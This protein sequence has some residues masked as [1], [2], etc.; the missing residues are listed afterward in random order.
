[1][2]AG[3]AVGAAAGPVGA[4]VGGLVG[5]VAGGM[6]ASVLQDTALDA[7][8]IN[9]TEQRQAN[10]E[11]NP[12]SA[13]AGDVAGSMA[14]FSPVAVGETVG[15]RL[16][17][18]AGGAVLQGGIEAGQELYQDGK[19]DPL[20]IA[21]T[22]A[23][24][25]VL[26][27]VN[28]LGSKVLNVGERLV[29]GRPNRTS[30]PEAAQ[31][32]ADVGDPEHEIAVGDSEL[33]E[34]DPN[35]PAQPTTGNPQ[36]APERSDREY[37]KD[38]AAAPGAD[39]GVTQGDMDP[40][41]QAALQE[42]NP[43]TPPAAPEPAPPVQR[44]LGMPPGNFQPPKPA[45]EAPLDRPAAPQLTPGQRAIA[46]SKRAQKLSLEPKVEAGFPA[47]GEP[48]A[49]GENEATAVASRPMPELQGQTPINDSITPAQKVAG[50][51]P[52]ARAQDFGKPVRVETHEGDVRRSH[53]DAPEAWENVSPYDYGYFGKTVGPDKDPIDFA[54]P[55]EGSPDLGDKHFIIDQKDATTGKY[56]EPKVFTYYK[57]EATAVDAYNRGFS[58]GKGPDRLHDITE[59]TRP[60][61]VKFLAKHSN[62]PPK[63]PYG[64][65]MPKV[66]KSPK[67]KA[68]FKDLI[69][70]KPELA[71]QLLNA[72][73]DKVA[74]AIEGK[75]VRKYGVNTGASAGYPVDGAL[76]SEGKPVTANTKL[77]A[78]ERAAKH[79]EVT[80]WYDESKPPSQMDLAQETNGELLDR[81]KPKPGRGD[82]T[83]WSPT[84]KPREW[85]W[86]R[87]ASA[88][89]KKP[90]PKAVTKFRDAERML[91][92]APED[93]E[94]YRGGNRVEADIARSKR[95]GD[96]AIATAENRAAQGGVNDAEDAAIAAIDAKRGAKFDVPHEEA[97]SM[98]KPTPVKSRADLK[99]IPHKTIDVGDSDLAKID[100]KAIS[101]DA[102]SKADARKA[103]AKALAGKQT[104]KEAKAPE[105]KKPSIDISDPVAMAKLIEMSN[106]AAKKRSASDEELGR[107]AATEDRG[108]TNETSKLFDSLRSFG[109][110]ETAA[111][112]V[113]KIKAD[114]KN[115]MKTTPAKS[116]IARPVHPVNEP[117]G[118]YTRALSDE[119]H[120]L[121]NKNTL[122]EQNV[123]DDHIGKLPK[124]KAEDMEAQQ[125]RI[126]QA[127]EADSA[128]VDLPGKLP[129]KTN[130]ESLSP[131]D[132]KIWDDHVK[133]LIDEGH[134]FRE[135]LRQI[136]PDMVGP[137]VEHYISRITKGNTP[138]FDA[139]RK[140]D[141][142]VI[143]RNG[144]ATSADMTNE[145]PFVALE[146]VAT[147]QRHVVQN[148]D[149]GFTWWNNQKASR[150]KDPSYSFEANKPYSV[151][152]NKTGAS[153]DYIM[154]HAMADE[155]EKSGARFD[156][157][158]DKN[159]K[160][161]TQR[162]TYHQNAMLSAALAH[163]QL[164]TM[165]RNLIELA[166]L[167]STKEF[168]ELSTRSS[169]EA[170]DKGWEETKMP[171]FK[172][173]YMAPEMREVFDDYAGPDSSFSALRNL[174][175]AV[176]KLLFWMPTAHIAN[177]GAHWFVG[178]GWDNLNVRRGFETSAKAMKS[179][180][181]QDHIQ[182]E[183][184]EN[185]AGL[186][187]PS[188]RT[189]NF[190]EQIAKGV[191]TKM[192]EDPK[193]GWRLLAQQAGVPFK[194]L[195]EAVYNNSSK[196][197]WAANDMFLTQRYLELKQ[198]G[199]DPKEAL[200]KAERDIPNYRIPTRFAGSGARG[201]QN[202]LIMQNT[203][204]LAFSRYHVGMMNAWSDTARGLLSTKSTVGDRVEALGKVLALGTL[205]AAC[206]MA[207]QVAQY[208]TG[209]EDATQNRRGPLAIPYHASQALQGKEDIASAAR[210]TLTLQ[211]LISTI[212]EAFNNKDFRGK[213]IV[214][215]DDVKRAAHG[216]VKA[217]GRAG[218]QEAE[219]GVRGL[220]SPLGTLESASK[221]GLNPAAAVRDQALDQKN[222]SDAARRFAKKQDII[223]FKNAN[224]RFKKGGSGVV[225]GWFDKTFGR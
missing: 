127:R 113:G 27:G 91:R 214:E 140:N 139:L 80:N 50:N 198:K 162:A 92:G 134:D 137:D 160:K 153:V 151:K 96:D 173:T 28:K 118:D 64:E 98:V 36:S 10:E 45:G 225:E 115:L 94:N 167:G 76:S 39:A 54:R 30:N 18:R 102:M 206:G 69:A 121:D 87:E 165:A 147:G 89:L 164:G 135:T 61:L 192:S 195:H 125:K 51:Y 11:A 201:R 144:L 9:D 182:K 119:L 223:N 157:G 156:L 97:E 130:I 62:N 31:A 8:G 224:Q 128:H 220:V 193:S 210:T 84:F 143:R 186:I 17:Q 47:P 55:K 14:G 168:N 37:P 154:R 123:L 71:E 70:K 83:G 107:G 187:Y 22:A 74:A 93:V 35:A 65:P 185:G 78:Q 24:G 122:H 13:F 171:N 166:R 57:D 42:A 120:T 67:D 60:E 117:H 189:R 44:P 178:R 172:G 126:Y 221:K 101:R 75:R 209:N 159:G 138:E 95:S 132:K 16:L 73:D 99:E 26:P 109:S 204:L 222:P 152:N 6:G 12:K 15:K 86:A 207:D 216:D 177:V 38:N 2:G 219:H 72:P 52:K 190:I 217:A 46:T 63:A 21:G 212:M 155:I 158:K 106:K 114:L 146:N 53:P 100:T 215:P 188:V 169:K 79:K 116:Y 181:S 7:A 56:D 131:E 90:T 149:G 111:L 4:F 1:M 208:V 175:Q 66:A 5:G 23:A 104:M 3:A 133:P 163:T 191:G 59:V 49:T 48:V 32:H 194:A 105:L 41:T 81:I 213:Q 203:N 200:A 82:L 33:A 112:N 142:P 196:A 170:K 124:M 174:N 180:I 205:A 179:V 77:K 34:A 176:T 183:M 197:M 58:D 211:P 184:M 88:L 161:L 108:S 103:E 150:I 129:G 20:K 218:I 43:D 40:A 110:D 148:R 68:V 25:A 29:P 202:S 136:D 85:L 141:D 19:V 145:R 199:L